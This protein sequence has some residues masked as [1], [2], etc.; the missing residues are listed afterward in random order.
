MTA[1]ILRTFRKA[2]SDEIRGI[3]T[4]ATSPKR[5]IMMRGPAGLHSVKTS[6]GP[7]EI[8]DYYVDPEH[9]ETGPSF[10]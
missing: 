3:V 4:I 9:E 7:H 5:S 1:D 2:Q 10:S 6:I 8:E